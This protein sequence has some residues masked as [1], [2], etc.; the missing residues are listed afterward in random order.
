MTVY[1]VKQCQKSQPQ[2]LNQVRLDSSVFLEM[3]WLSPA[4]SIESVNK[5]LLALKRPFGRINLDMEYFLIC[6]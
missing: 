3:S 5:S 6:Y 1:F 2:H 4:S